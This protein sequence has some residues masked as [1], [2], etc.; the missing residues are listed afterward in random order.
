MVIVSNRIKLLSLTD[1]IYIFDNG[2]IRNEGSHEQLL[3]KDPFYQAMF[4]KQMKQISGSEE[5]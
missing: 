5:Q 2:T 3:Q 4:E 1:I